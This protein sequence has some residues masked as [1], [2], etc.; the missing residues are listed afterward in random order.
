MRENNRWYFQWD[1]FSKDNTFYKD[2][3]FLFKEWIYPN[4]LE[5]FSGKTVLDCGCGRGQHLKILLPYIKS[6]VGVDLY[7]EEVAKKYIVD[8]K[9]RIIKGDIAMM[10]LPEKFDIVYSIGVIHHTDSPD[11][12]FENMKKHLKKGGKM[13]IWVYAHEG[14][15]LNWALLEPL[16]KYFLKKINKRVLLWISWLITAFLY[17]PVYTIYLL[18]LKS[19]PF[20]YYFGNFRKLSFARNYLNIFDKLNA[21]QT[22]FIRRKTIEKWF[23]QREFKDVHISHYLGVS[24]RASGTLK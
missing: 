22:H 24:W 20:Y 14:N 5:D 3:I 9:I 17:I 21:P 8:E 11:V 15:F 2:D 7:T 6:G 23:N 16:K 10:S 19:L 4:T 12:T 13:I 1:S 18:P